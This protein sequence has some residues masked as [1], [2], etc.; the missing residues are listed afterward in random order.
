[1]FINGFK[2][3]FFLRFN[4]LRFKKKG[5]I[6]GHNCRVFNKVYLYRGGNA[7]IKI[8]DNFLFRSGDGLNPLSRNLKGCIYVENNG[9]LL[10]GNNVG[11]S[12]SC[13]WCS[14]SIVIGDNVLIGADSCILDSD[15]HSLDYKFR[16][17]SQLD[18]TNK[19]NKCITIGNDVFI[20]MKCLILKGVTLGDRCVVAAGS[21]VTKSFPP[22]CVIAGN[23]A[24]KITK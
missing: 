2:Q 9:K 1:M 19:V 24:K 5:I 13:I 11:M 21:V 3:K 16:R 8:G 10:I 7:L 17:D 22:D 6:Y 18:Q 4:L 20:G 15:C 14:D 23:P 12:S